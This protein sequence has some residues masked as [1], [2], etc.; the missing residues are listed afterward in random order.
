[1]F[2]MN[3]TQVSWSCLG[4]LVGE[5]SQAAVTRKLHYFL[6]MLVWGKCQL[7]VNICT[8]SGK[9]WHWCSWYGYT[10]VNHTHSLGAPPLSTPQFRAE[11]QTATAS[12][13]TSQPLGV[14]TQKERWDKIGW[15]NQR[16]LIHFHKFQMT[17]ESISRWP[18]HQIT[19]LV[20]GTAFIFF[21]RTQFKTAPII[22]EWK[23]MIFTEQLQLINTQRTTGKD[24]TLYHGNALQKMLK[25]SG[26]G[27]WGTIQRGQKFWKHR[28][29][30]STHD[31]DVVGLL[32]VIETQWPPKDWDQTGRTWTWQSIST[33]REVNQSV[34]L[35][36]RVKFS[37]Q[38]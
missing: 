37:T 21:I 11:R 19:F 17:R 25:R 3:R 13:L 28:W 7:L 26:R 4:V 22:H 34:T 8:W 16:W 23:L 35:D 29:Y 1:M 6:H 24:L 36:L 33:F 5:L 15:K 38:S 10:Y 27:W 20:V 31:S 2:S 12:I 9:V 18:G 32:L 30:F 14:Q